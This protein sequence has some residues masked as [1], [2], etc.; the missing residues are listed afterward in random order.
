MCG[1]LHTE[2]YT[3]VS[4]LLASSCTIMVLCF[5][6]FKMTCC[7]EFV[8]VL[9]KVWVKDLWL[10]TTSDLLKVKYFRLLFALYNFVRHKTSFVVSYITLPG[11][12]TN[13]LKWQG[14]DHLRLLMFVPFDKPYII[15][16]YIVCH[17]KDISISVSYTH[18]TLPT[19]RIV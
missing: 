3:L 12:I 8:N 2:H 1:N 5:E 19:K 4:Q 7:C 14:Q 10:D 11:Y 15:S 9:L 18:L 13:Y 17:C 6:M 16:Y